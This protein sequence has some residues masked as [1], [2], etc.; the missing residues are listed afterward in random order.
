MADLADRLSAHWPGH[1]LNKRKRSG[2]PWAPAGV[3][4]CA[5]S[6]PTFRLFVL[7]PG[8][9]GLLVHAGGLLDQT[10]VYRGREGHAIGV[11]PELVE[12]E[13]FT[14]DPIAWARG[15]VRRVDAQV[16]G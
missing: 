13:A 16:L 12:R 6:P 4:D 1:R 2:H 11:Q 15:V 10:L 5:L 7:P 14:D 9:T 3:P 8:F